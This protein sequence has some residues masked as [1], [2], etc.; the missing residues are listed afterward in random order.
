MQNHKEK[1]QK[2]RPLRKRYAIVT[3]SRGRWPFMAS[4]PGIWYSDPFSKK[5]DGWPVVRWMMHLT[6]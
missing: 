4:Y 1:Q 6:I 3:D 5:R 2:N